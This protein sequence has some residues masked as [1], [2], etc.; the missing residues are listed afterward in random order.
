M[1]FYRLQGGK[2]VED[3]AEWDWLELLEQLGD[4]GEWE[5]L[6]LL[7]HMEATTAGRTS[8]PT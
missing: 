2:I 5:W 8:Q 4:W 3:W 1:A 7:K 6:D